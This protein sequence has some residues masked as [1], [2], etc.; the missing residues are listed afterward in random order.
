MRSCATIFREFSTRLLVVETDIP[1][2][3]RVSQEVTRRPSSFSTKHNLQAP[4]GLDQDDNRDEE[5]KFHFWWQLGELCLPLG[6]YL[7]P[8]NS[9]FYFIHLKCL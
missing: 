3:T 8:I 6:L 9:E 2:F 7:Y 5:Y 1:P 4:L